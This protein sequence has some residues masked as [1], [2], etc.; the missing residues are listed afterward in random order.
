MRDYYA[1]REIP[2]SAGVYCLL[3]YSVRGLYPAY[4]GL[5]GNLQSRISQ[6]LEYRNSSVTTGASAVSLD[7]SQVGGCRWWTDPSFEDATR[8]GAAELVAFDVLNPVLRSRSGINRVSH[9]LSNDPEFR[10]W[11]ET[12]FSGEGGVVVF[13]GITELG[14]EIRQSKRGSMP[15][16]RRSGEDAIRQDSRR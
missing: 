4:V 2:K 10:Q 1:L 11:A 12:L 5:G 6:H 8:L 14:R 13:P 3:G 9:E 16:R 7:A 15:W